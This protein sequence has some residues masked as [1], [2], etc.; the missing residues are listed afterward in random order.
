MNV[1]DSARMADVLAPLGYTA[2]D[3]P[4]GA[5]MVIMN[6]CH[7][8]E[9][10]ADKVFSAL[11]RLRVLKDETRGK[12]LIAVTGCVAQA[13][14][15]V[16]LKRA[17]YVDLVVGP[18]AYHRLPELIAR[19]HRTKN[20]VIDTDFPAEQKFDH[21]PD[22]AASQGV[23]ANLTIQEGCDKFCSF[24]VVP[25]T[26]G[27]E[28]SRPAA[29][30]LA[31]AQRMVEGGTREIALLGQNVNAYHGPGPDGS[32]WTLARLLHALGQIPR[33]Q[34][35][36]YTTSHPSDMTDELIFAHRDNPALMPYLHLPVQSGSDKIL[37]VMNRKHTADD[38]RRIVDKLRKV[39]PDMAFTSD[40]IIGHP[41]ET[42]A[43]F[44]AT[45]ALVR[46]TRFALAYSFNYSPRPGTP[47]AALPQIPVE[48]KDARLY[49]LQAE[50]R[51]QQDEFN[52]A[53]VGLTMPVLFTGNG[54]YPGQIAGRSPY[55]QPV[56]VESPPLTG[57]IRQVQITHANPNSLLGSLSHSTQETI[58][59]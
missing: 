30:I 9:R 51:R 14:G 56:V 54:R 31:E 38:F 42:E 7:I 34:R 53:S 44:Q 43:D 33:L 26:R 23:I 6:T 55:A 40:F 59:A 11:G 22:A 12:M 39:R 24:C 18:Q 15:D 21:L 58:A 13:E 19:V 10:A 52:L 50:L 25:Y 41:G 37:R 28:A 5:D 1:Y 3:T 8:R 49:E 4:V 32:D 27:A 29:A 2:V 46:E 48:V 17:P 45:M 35:L 36:R 57:E 20:A 16:I 47:A